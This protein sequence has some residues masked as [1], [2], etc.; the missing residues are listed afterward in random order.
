MGMADLSGVERIV[1]Q[2][3]R[4]LLA[5][6]ALRLG[7]IGTA[8]GSAAALLASSAGKA[9]WPEIGTVWLVA[10]PIAAGLLA[11]LTLAISRRPSALAAAQRL[12]QVLR[13]KDGL[14]SALALQPASKQDAAFVAMTQADAARLAPNVQAARATPLR[15]GRAWPIASALVAGALAVGWWAPAGLWLP[16]PSA[17]RAAKLAEEAPRREAAQKAIAEARQLLETPT[18]ADVTGA[19]SPEELAALDELDRELRAGSTTPGEVERRSATVLEQASRRI[20]RESGER[21]ATAEAVREKLAALKQKPA[22]EDSALARALKAADPATAAQEA[23]ELSDRLAQMS[24]EER[25]EVSR[26]LAELAEQLRGEPNAG[27]AADVTDKPTATEQDLKRLGFSDQQIEALRDKPLEDVAKSLEQ[28]GLEPETAER[29]ADRLE[30][31]REERRQDQDARERAQELAKS[32]DAAAEQLR[33]PENPPT[34]S[35]P[36][37]GEN[38]TPP[39][40]GSE[41]PATPEKPGPEAKPDGTKTAPPSS[42]PT[43]GDNSPTKDA[44]APSEPKTAP[45][46]R[47][48]AGPSSNKAPPDAPDS[49]GAAPKKSDKGAP[50]DTK[51]GTKGPAKSPDQTSTQNPS[52]PGQP[53]AKDPPPATPERTAE[54]GPDGQDA[55]KGKQPAPGADPS[56]PKGAPNTPNPNAAPNPTS[57]PGGEQPAPGEQ[58]QPDA[59]PKDGQTKDNQSQEGQP[60]GLASPKDGTPPSPG[61]APERQDS[62]APGPLP[63]PD[64]SPQ[65]LE[66]LADELER[67]SRDADRRGKPPEVSEEMRQKAKEMFESLS[68]DERQKLNEL[69]QRLAREPGKE[70]GEGRAGDREATPGAGRRAG[71]SAPTSDSPGD[72]VRNG[73]PPAQASPRSP[74]ES[75]LVDAPRPAGGARSPQERVVGELPRRDGRVTRG[76]E[77]GPA[78]TEQ[79][80]REAAESGQRA[81]ADRLVPGR[82]APAIREYFKRLPRTGGDAVP[83]PIT[84]PAPTPPATVPPVTKPPPG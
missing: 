29:M 66:K 31:D 55:G 58:G 60:N 65:G 18:D 11:G 73:S 49:P 13:L 4:R 26:E 17:D 74:G 84:P 72:R 76:S 37:D 64:L 80:L 67:L 46:Q 20:E 71:E 22:A 23:R 50:S 38:R 81:I 12:D 75:R 6:A 7:G 30:R 57:G 2:A 33:E 45:E 48:G 5:D 9:W 10:T 28:Q 15:L 34:E 41:Q 69:A 40:S 43:K 19:A 21:S 47:E 59:L 32:L 36:S 79:A 53:A 68:P 62:P 1:A 51:S 83:S 24:P 82:L 54:P 63:K 39:V 56:G 16:S 14:A 8:W 61:A 44:G 27:E 25:A 70:P 52:A 35:K 3:R 42:T 78:A 77:T